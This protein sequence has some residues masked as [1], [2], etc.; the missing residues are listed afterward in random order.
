MSGR[1]G[2]EVVDELVAGGE[3]RDLVRLV[4]L[5]ADQRSCSG[6][7]GPAAGARR[8]RRRRATETARAASPDAGRSAIASASGTLVV[9][10]KCSVLISQA[11]FQSAR[12]A[13][14]SLGGDPDLPALRQ[15]RRGTGSSPFSRCGTHDDLTQP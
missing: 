3:V 5:L 12:S 11:E 6:T 2:A 15:A 1:A 14:A 8:S 4:G 7:A 10:W 13:S 9:I